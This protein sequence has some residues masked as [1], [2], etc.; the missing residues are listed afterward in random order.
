MVL[1]ATAAAAAAARAEF[2]SSKFFGVFRKGKWEEEGEKVNF[3]QGR[4]LHSSPIVVV[5]L[6]LLTRI[7]HFRERMEDG[8]GRKNL[9]EIR[10]ARLRSGEEETGKGRKEENMFSSGQKSYC[11]VLLNYIL[12]KSFLL[13]FFFVR[14]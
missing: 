3:A 9:I 6:L 8:R 13:W 10:V 12:Q 7:P 5:L 4:N 11:S 14:T 1:H 2:Y